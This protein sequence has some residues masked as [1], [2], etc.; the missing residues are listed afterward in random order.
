M[1]VTALGPVV[2]HQPSTGLLFLD[3]DLNISSSVSCYFYFLF[4]VAYFCDCGGQLT[5]FAG[6]SAAFFS[7]F[8]SN[9]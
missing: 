5:P 1:M 3:L 8:F 2:S 6:M 7:S 4:L 9:C